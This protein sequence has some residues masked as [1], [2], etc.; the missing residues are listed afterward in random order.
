MSRPTNHV[1]ASTTTR[2]RSMVD[3]LGSLAPARV[4]LS[5]FATTAATCL[6]FKLMRGR[7]LRPWLSSSGRSG[8][9]GPVLGSQVGTPEAYAP[10]VL[11]PVP[12]ALGR[13]LLGLGNGN[14]ELPFRGV[15][16]WTCYEASWL[17][18]DG[19]P[20]RH[21]IELRVPCTSP[22][23]VESKSLK[24]YLNSL[25]FK[26]FP[27]DA[28]ALR[29]ICE[30]VGRVVEAPV[31]AQILKEE[32]C[33][34]TGWTLLEQP[35]SCGGCLPLEGP[36]PPSLGPPDASLLGLSTHA[37]DGRLAKERLTTNLLRTLCPV[38][39]QPDWGSLFIEYEGPA[40]DKAGLLR[41]I[42]SLRREIGFHE[43]AVETVY[44]AILARC[45]PA[46]LS[47]MGRFLRRGGID[48]NPVRAS[49]DEGAAQAA[50]TPLRVL[51]Q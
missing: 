48:I 27:D 6:A 51:G 9:T 37:A 2:L 21:V 35:A 32:A 43:N 17:G 33:L 15:D 39:S 28:T 4:V 45:R 44:L 10:E 34:A 46:K 11:Y 13:G 41:Y 42:C 16:I 26:A 23:L 31:S 22:M 47:V 1:R 8:S 3:A 14:D 50:A 24:L 5:A 49:S 18:K 40:L 19:V 29:T 12:R 7:L 38:T 20:C 25:N 36:E 30:D